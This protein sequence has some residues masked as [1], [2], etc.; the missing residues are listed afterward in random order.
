MMP[1]FRPRNACQILQF[2]FFF[3]SFCAV[4]KKMPRRRGYRRGIVAGLVVGFDDA[5]NLYM[6][7]YVSLTRLEKI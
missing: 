2:F 6:R 5:R 3:E 4:I 7:P 1:E